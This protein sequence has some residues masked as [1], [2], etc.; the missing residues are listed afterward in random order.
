[1]T[2]Q[3]FSSRTEHLGKEFLAKILQGAVKYHRIAGYFRS[4]IFELIGE[5]IADIPDVKIVCNSELEICDFQIAARYRNSALKELWN[6]IDDAAE[7]LLHRERYRRLDALLASKHIEIR[8]VPKERIF[9]HGKAGL[10]QYKNGSKIA[11]IG[12][13]NE[14]KSAF[15]N[16]YE[17][18]WKDDESE[19]ADWVEKEFQSLWR[20]GIPLPETIYEEIH[21]V[22]NRQEVSINVVAPKELPG[23]AF[24]ESPIYRGG[25]ELQPWQ[26][27][28]VTLFL[29]HREWY[30]KARLLLADE[31]GVGK[32]LS[33]AASA[34]LTAL[35][36]DGPAL[37]LAPATLTW[38]WQAEL[39]DKLGVPS[40]V[41]SSEMQS[42]LDPNA[43]LL[44]PRKDPSFISRCPHKIAIISTGLI[45]QQFSDGKFIKDAERLLAR[46]YGIVI[47]DEA[48]KARG[49][50]NEKDETKER[51]PNNLLAFMRQIAKK[52][53]HIILGTAT[54][55][56]T[57]VRDLWDLLDILRSGAEFVL[58]DNNSVWRDVKLA[59]PFITGESVP[60]T[61]D[62][63]LNCICNPLPPEGENETIDTICN[64][65]GFNRK[66]YI[67]SYSFDELSPP[68]Q[69]FVYNCQTPDF[70]KNCNPVLR[71]VVLRKREDL[72]KAGL[73]I[74]VGVNAHPDRKRS[75][76]YDYRFD[77]LGLSTN[78]PFQ[79]AYEKAEEFCS[80]LQKRVRTA[81]FMKTL[82]LQRICSSFYAG[83]KTAENML[84]QSFTKELYDPEEKINKILS[85]MTKKEV[86]CLN[87]I[88]LQLSRNEAV[89]PKLDTVKWFLQDFRTDGKTWLE[90]GCIIFSQYYDTA[91]WIASKLNECF[92]NESVAVYAGAGKSRLYYENESAAIEREEIKKAVKKHEIRLLV[93]TDAACE[94]LNL[95]TLG[96][97]INIDLP[98]NPSRLEQRLCRIKRFGQRRKSVDMLNLVYNNTQDEKVYSALSERLHDIHKIFGSIPDTI[99]D[100]WIDNEEELKERINI[101]IEEREK[102]QNSFTAK[103]NTTVDPDKNKWDL[104]T[105]VLSR[106]DITDI[107]AESW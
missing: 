101:Y 99:E 70:L 53:K 103:Y 74:K 6:T 75:V 92:P 16:N 14:T 25:E 58:G 15:N 64:I 23:A 54:P 17:L 9:L 1:M 22:A 72:E 41:W 30:G 24:A 77:G 102:A 94:G 21:R 5:E 36:G 86:E 2:L 93:A 55:I 8:V 19:S 10:V 26:R 38:Q 107:L 105:K 87:E 35:L 84:E 4:S 3:R 52:T 45:V 85:E 98:W 18:V 29:K 100:E 69:N 81:G 47:L 62:A 31:V 40:A 80:L 50:G 61:P 95:Q 96:T 91:E 51:I 76:L 106:R 37:I 27:S 46:R 43:H 11:F 57:S 39:L 68:S 60:E 83:K 73:M 48:H 49:H 82:L 7:S 33:M 20:D 12:S 44:S 65:E 90:H 79:T 89:D 63:M 88:K 78:M 97:L 56:Q 34:V 71:H 42:W 66:K 32:T 67:Q 59:V 28:F 104:C 13:V